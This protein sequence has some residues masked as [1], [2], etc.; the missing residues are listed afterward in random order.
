MSSPSTNSAPSWYVLH[1]KRGEEDRAELNLRGW[2]VETFSPRIKESR[3]IKSRRGAVSSVRPLFPQYLFARFDI[4][5]LLHKIKLTRGVNSVISFGGNPVPVDDDIVSLLKA[6]SQE[7]GLI[8]L[9]GKFKAGDKLVVTDG[10]LKN[11]VGIFE[12]EL[13]DMGRIEIL[14]TTINY[15][16][17]V[18]ID[19]TLIEKLD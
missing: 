6:Q 7:D 12:C 2:R 1:T 10:P 3:R 17:R 13:D 15:Q 18:V 9:D 19:K 14:L 4:N 8:H 16:G 11:L 5:Q